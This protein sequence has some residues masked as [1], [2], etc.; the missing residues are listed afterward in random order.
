MDMCHVLKG[1][2]ISENIPFRSTFLLEISDGS[3]S[4]SNKTYTRSSRLR[5]HRGGIQILYPL[6]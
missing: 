3:I 6:Q 1:V 5:A 2:S 4:H